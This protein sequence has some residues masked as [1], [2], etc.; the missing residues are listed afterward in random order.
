MSP[1]NHV[2]RKPWE[3]PPFPIFILIWTASYNDKYYILSYIC[4]GKSVKIKSCTLTLQAAIIQFSLS[5]SR[6]KI[7]L[8]MQVHNVFCVHVILHCNRWNTLTFDIL[9]CWNSK[10]VTNQL[11][12]EFTFINATEQIQF[13]ALCVKIK[14]TVTLWMFLYYNNTTSN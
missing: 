2:G 13:K 6:V 11:Y 7:A 4:R 12:A 1:L 9:S 14:S 8:I 5:W 3:W 10:I